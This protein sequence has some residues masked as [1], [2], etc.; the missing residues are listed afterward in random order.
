MI[1]WSDVIRPNR[2]LK[3]GSETPPRGCMFHVDQHAA[4]T[5][6]HIRWCTCRSGTGNS[7]HYYII[8]R[9]IDFEKLID[10]DVNCVVVIV[11][12]WRQ[13]GRTFKHA[14]S[15]QYRAPAPGSAGSG[16]GSRCRS[17]RMVRSRSYH[18]NSPHAES[19][20]ESR[21]LTVQVQSA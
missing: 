15:Y 5:Y 21:Q 7:L 12:K 19:M 11:K 4:S 1:S 13:R 18:G 6:T 8:C 16:L 20:F 9:C 14:C 2:V 17:S 3:K 10:N